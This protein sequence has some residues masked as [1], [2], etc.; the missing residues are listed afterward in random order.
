MKTMF[1]IGGDSPIDA[2]DWLELDTITSSPDVE[3]SIIETGDTGE[4]HRL[5]KAALIADRNGPVVQQAKHAKLVTDFMR[6][7]LSWFVSSELGISNPEIL[8]AQ[9]HLLGQGSFIGRHV[10]NEYN[11][12]YQMSLTF[13]FRREYTGGAFVTDEGNRFS[14]NDNALIVCPGHVGHEV[15]VVTEGE[16]KTLAVFLGERG[17]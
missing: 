11:P 15:E 5:K 2:D 7:R 1:L 4:P 16:R 6:T 8:R 3:F 13:H 12:G 14:S 17:R 10:D 9:V